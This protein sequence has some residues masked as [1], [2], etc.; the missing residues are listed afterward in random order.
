M[1][2]MNKPILKI[3]KAAVVEIAISDELNAVEIMGFE[4]WLN[5]KIG[6]S[7]GGWL[8]NYRLNLWDPVEIAGLILL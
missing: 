8:I 7:K 6:T 4:D 2:I 1:K 5:D 3:I